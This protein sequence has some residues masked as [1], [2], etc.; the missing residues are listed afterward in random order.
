MAGALFLETE[1]LSQQAVD[2]C[3]N[4]IQ[5]PVAMEIMLLVWSLM[6]VIHTLRS[7]LTPHLSAS[8]HVSPKS[9]MLE[10][11]RAGGGKASW[12]WWAAEDTGGTWCREMTGHLGTRGRQPNA[13][14][15]VLQVTRGYRI[16]KCFFS[17][18][19]GFK[20]GGLSS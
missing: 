5:Q 3:L 17:G 6:L 9:S 4:S 12:S 7:Y 1:A 2:C 11:L 15:Q 20:S 14:Q 19:K 16:K 10:G 18:S 8:L 13:L